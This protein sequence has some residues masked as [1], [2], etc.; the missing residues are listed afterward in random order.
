VRNSHGHEAGGPSLLVEVFELFSSDDIMSDLDNPQ[1]EL[2]HRYYCVST[3]VEDVFSK[4]VESIGQIR[5]DVEEDVV[6]S[7]AIGLSALRSRGTYK[8]GNFFMIVFSKSY[9]L[10]S[11]RRDVP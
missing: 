8:Q 4:V 2:S 1:L 10:G 6:I 3:E 9:S 11:G 5:Q 7:S